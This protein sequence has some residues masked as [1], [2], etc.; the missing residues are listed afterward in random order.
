MIKVR[1]TITNVKYLYKLVECLQNDFKVL[2]VSDAYENNRGSIKS[3]YKRVYI[4][5]ESKK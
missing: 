2:Q 1:A 4:E 5:I 3:T